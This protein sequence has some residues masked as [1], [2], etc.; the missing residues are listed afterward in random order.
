MAPYSYDDVDEGRKI[1]EQEEGEEGTMNDE[2]RESHLKRIHSYND[3][4]GKIHKE[5]TQKR[6]QGIQKCVYND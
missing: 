6:G 3:D 5:K 1:R 2:K 4:E